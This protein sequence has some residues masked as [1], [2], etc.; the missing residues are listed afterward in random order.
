V[1]YEPGELR[2][3][4]YRDGREWTRDAVQTTGP[5]ARLELKSEKSVIAADGDDLA[6]VNVS[7]RDGEGRVVPRME[8]EVTFCVEGPGEI[9]ATDNGDE[10]D[11]SDFHKPVRRVLNGWAQVIVRAHRGANG[12]IVVRATAEGLG[13]AASKVVVENGKGVAR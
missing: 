5:A 2:V 7:V 6:F 8:T 1:I 12:E 4:V 10:R 9:V 13:A 11:F 3:V